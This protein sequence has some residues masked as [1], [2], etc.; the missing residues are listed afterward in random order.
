MD[1]ALHVVKHVTMRDS[2][3]IEYR[4][5]YLLGDPS[6]EMHFDEDESEDIQLDRTYIE[7][8]K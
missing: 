3:M 2:A 6:L 7:K 5:L 1:K 8:E 4:I